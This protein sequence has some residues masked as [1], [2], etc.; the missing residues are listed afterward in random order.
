MPLNSD[1]KK[2]VAGHVM[3]LRPFNFHIIPG[4]RRGSHARRAYQDLLVVGV[5]WPQTG[6]IR[7]HSLWRSADLAN[8]LRI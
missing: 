1:E 4:V 8:N 5:K 3:R 7:P 2:Q 6:A